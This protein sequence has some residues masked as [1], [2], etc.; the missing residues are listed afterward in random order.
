MIVKLLGL[1]DILASLVLLTSRFMPEKV[2][3]A[4]GFYLL[5]KG[6]L[7]NIFGLNAVSLIDA[8]IGAFML[9]GVYTGFSITFFRVL[10]FVFLVQ[11][12]VFSF[13]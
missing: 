2:L 4:F 3:M 9:I 6:L 12:G 10:F 5:I 13:F 11:K 1:V 7:F 8:A